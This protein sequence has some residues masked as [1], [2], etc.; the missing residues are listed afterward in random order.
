MGRPPRSSTRP[1][2]SCCACYDTRRL[3]VAHDDGRRRHA[4][5]QCQHV[6]AT[7]R[8]FQVV[9]VRRPGYPDHAEDLGSCRRAF[10]SHGHIAMTQVARLVI[11]EGG[12]VELVLG[13]GRCV[14]HEAAQVAAGSVTHATLE[15]A[16][17]EVADVA[18]DRFEP[19]ADLLEPLVCSVVHVRDVVA[20]L[21][22]LDLELCQPLG[23]LEQLLREQDRAQLVSRGWASP[24]LAD[25]GER[26]HT[27]RARQVGGRARPWPGAGFRRTGQCGPVNAARFRAEAGLRGCR[28]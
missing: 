16:A 14:S 3:L 25:D 5:R 24:H 28:A 11:A 2:P 22:D 23:K 8:S 21:S 26:A 10:A 19:L 17:L 12:R 1:A 15:V 20:G 13:D 9:L 27:L 4:R 6:G 18:V 7:C